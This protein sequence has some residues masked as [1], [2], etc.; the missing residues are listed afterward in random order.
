[1]GCNALFGRGK[2]EVVYVL[3]VYRMAPKQES[4]PEGVQVVSVIPERWE[5]W[6]QRAPCL[7]VFG[8]LR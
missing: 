8:A 5:E 1:M 3:W 7:G 2:F 4:T 6:I